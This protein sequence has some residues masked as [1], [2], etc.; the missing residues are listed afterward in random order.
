MDGRT[1]IL[2]GAK[3]SGSTAVFRM[4][5]RHPDVGVCHVDQS[6][7]NWEPNFWNLAA[8]SIRGEPAPFRER[9]ARCCPFLDGVAP[10]S[11]DQACA[12][13]GRIL[14][15]LGPI[16]FDKSPRYLRDTEPMELILGY[17][18]DHD[19]RLIGIVRDPRDVVSSQYELWG[20]TRAHDTPQWREAC[21]VADYERLAS[22][23][24]RMDIPVFRYEDLVSQPQ[25][26]GPQMLAH[27]GLSCPEACLA[28]LRPT[29]IGRHQRTASEALKAWTPGAGMLGLM[30]RYGYAGTE[31]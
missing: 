11:R 13:W 25:R 4:F 3:R 31:G 12:I 8:E 15:E 22:W 26:I 10:A 19:V 30:D 27:A 9:F 28:H 21:W 24:S 14:A 18:R 5:Q 2:L 23:Q 17:A 6:I 16:V 7:D 20:G 29:N 1:I